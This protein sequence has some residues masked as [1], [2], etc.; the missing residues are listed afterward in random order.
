M[1]ILVNLSRYRSRAG[2]EALR[3]YQIRCRVPNRVSVSQPAAIYFA[4]RHADLPMADERYLE[5]LFVTDPAKDMDTI[6]QNNDRLLDGS[7]KWLQ[8]DTNYNEWE[9][10]HK[11]RVLWISGDPGKGKTMLAISMIKRLMEKMGSNANSSNT[12]LAYFF[13]D[14]KDSRRSSTIS[15]LRSLIYQIL[16]QRP[17]LT[18]H[19]K[20]VYEREEEQFF[21]SPNAV[22]TLWYVLQSLIS[23][24]NLQNVYFI[25]DA[26]DELD[27]QSIK[28][29]L[30]LL[31]PVLG[32]EAE[33]ADHK[34]R[35]NLDRYCQVKWLVT[36]R[37]IDFI[38]HSMAKQLNISLEV[39]A[40]HVRD[41]VW[42][43]IDRAV[44]ELQKLKGYGSSLTKY[45]RDTLREKSEGT[46]LYVS[47]ACRELSQP[48]IRL[49]TTKSV[50]ATMP[51][52]LTPL[53]QRIMD[54]VTAN[55][56]R[57]LVE[58]AK[59]I[60][61]AM[62][63]AVRPLTVQEIAIAADLPAEYHDDIDILREYIGLCGS[64][65][66]RQQDTVYFVHLSV[67]TYLC[68]VD[69]VFHLPV[70]EYHA[71]L[72]R[73]F[74]AH[75]CVSK[76]D[77]KEEGKEIILLE[78]P[79]S[80]WMH[81]AQSSESS[82]NWEQ[83]LSLELFSNTSRSR[84]QWLNIYWPLNNPEWE[85]QPAR[86]SPLHLAA[87]SGIHG[88]VMA[89]L[90]R[91]DPVDEA[92]SFGHTAL[93]WA[94]KGGYNDIVKLLLEHGANLETKTQNGLT[95]LVFAIINGHQKVVHELIKQGAKVSTTDKLGWTPLHHAA[96]HGHTKILGDILEAG[97]EVNIKDIAQQSALQRAAFCC[98]LKSIQILV[99]WKADVSVTD[100]DKCTLLHRSCGDGELDLVTFWIK[101]FVDIEA[102]DNQSWTSL[103]H[104]AWNGHPA[105][106]A[107]L[108][109]NGAKLESKAMDGS[110][111]LHL[112]TWN[113]HAHVT[114]V[115][116]E[117][118]ANPNSEDDM[119]ET[120]LQQAAWRGHIGVCRVLLKSGA[121]PNT[122]SDSGVTPLHQAASNGHDAVVRLLFEWA[123]EPNAID[124][125]N[126]TP[127]ARAEESGHLALAELLR[128]FE[129]MDENEEY[130]TV[131][132]PGEFQVVDQAVSKLLDVPSESCMG[133]SQGAGFSKYTKIIAFVNGET[134]YY[135]MKSS[136]KEEVISSKHILD[137]L[138]VFNRC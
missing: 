60:L 86:F 65:V 18:S 127:A 126:I 68:S 107:F 53:Y 41:A 117:G 34:L 52:G 118:K 2:R 92:D 85:K 58:H 9:N 108:I 75:I 102:T 66:T 89:V 57:D 133:Q 19:F 135:F 72:T 93:I 110:T 3:Q 63:L 33:N 20:A 115:L 95:A 42:K 104:A 56:D 73:F 47:V 27:L 6:E 91:G 40:G 4:H 35:W 71:Q 44:E 81:H 69:Q 37:N 116:L 45:V 88:L 59:A 76:D 43:F 84:Q 1:P 130:E 36:S 90:S 98:D 30:M 62:V 103:M 24:S 112:A 101:H 10:P 50:L 120:P 99:D 121:D 54:Q 134:T 113:G 38:S 67:K 96:T 106:A 15:V 8:M 97:A 55:A 29:L 138:P 94:A 132:H 39:N 123:A 129:T 26:L 21:T 125:L 131:Q 105:V 12:L 48:E 23:R 16:V 80:S 7:G 46:F 49:L 119:H 137:P 109:Q 100:K 28:D 114:K 77:S 25:I 13:C 83:N 64:F 11:S 17:D 111:A 136:E 31:G 128:S 78:Y 70:S 61:R 79:C 74:L 51:R 122:R 22:Q 5:I 124:S 82:I 32:S 87:Y 14:N